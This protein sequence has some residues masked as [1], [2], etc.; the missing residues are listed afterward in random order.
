MSLIVIS[1]DS[2]SWEM[3]DSHASIPKLDG[4]Q[5]R[6]WL[7]PR[8]RFLPTLEAMSSMTSAPP[9]VFGGT[10]TTGS[11]K[12][13]PSAHRCA[14]WQSW[15]TSRHHHA[16]ERFRRDDHRCLYCGD[17]FPE[18]TTQIMW[19]RRRGGTDKWENV[20]AVCKRCN[21]LKDAYA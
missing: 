4:R 3:N 8:K 11:I 17:Q 20:V 6:G 12:A 13:H 16:T 7:S 2:V 10:V 5:P 9:P 19:Y 15:I 14:Q 21:W 1:H 18:G